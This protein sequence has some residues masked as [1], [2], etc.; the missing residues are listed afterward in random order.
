[1]KNLE[2][3]LLEIPRETFTNYAFFIT[4]IAMI[5][6]ATT[7]NVM[8]PKTIIK[9]VDNLMLPYDALYFGISFPI[10]LNESPLSR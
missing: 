7:T 6:G 5:A 9:I 10:T 1:M 2:K 8:Q 3:F 4:I